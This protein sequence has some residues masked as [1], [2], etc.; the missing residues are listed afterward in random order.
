M[1]EARDL[2]HDYVGTEHLL[3]GL[4]HGDSTPA[5]KALNDAGV[6]LDRARAEALRL[7][8]AEQVSEW[9]EAARPDPRHFDPTARAA[10]F[11]AVVA[12]AVAIAALVMALVHGPR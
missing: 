9:G 3:L 1:W 4:L 5:V 2:K 11:V 10:L 7:V 8:G 12:F 6:T